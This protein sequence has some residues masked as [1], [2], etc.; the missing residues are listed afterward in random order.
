MK[1]VDVGARE[2]H[3]N[4][5]FDAREHRGVTRRSFMT[6]LAVLGCAFP[7]VLPAQQAQSARVRRIGLVIGEEVEGLEAAF[8]ET[9]RN[10]GYIEGQNLLI[11]ARYSL[12]SP[13]GRG[14][15]G[16]PGEHGFR[17]SGRPFAGL[18]PCGPEGQPVH[19]SG[20][21]DYARDDQQWVRKVHRTPWR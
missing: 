2:A 3:S 19:A 1:R 4:G 20:H 8:R 16:G 18:R 13:S 17:V 5:G 21:R 12:R 9:L 10:Q 15:H 14:C 6:G 11:E 7:V